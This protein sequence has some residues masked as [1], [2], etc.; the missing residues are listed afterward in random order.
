MGLELVT[1]NSKWVKW[2]PFVVMMW[3]TLQAFQSQAPDFRVFYQ[4]AN[5]VGLGHSAEI[6]SSPAIHD[7]FLYAPGFA[8]L[9]IPFSW[10]NYS[11]AL[12]L[13]CLI[14][15]AVLGVAVREYGAVGF[16][17][18]LWIVR[19]LGI[20]FRY[21]QV[22]SLIL[23]V[24]VWALVSHFNRKSTAR[25]SFL[26]FF[27][28]G[29]CAMTKI[30][31][32]SLLVVPWL[33]VQLQSGIGIK[34]VRWE[35][36][37]GLTGVAFVLLLPFAFVGVESAIT[38]HQNWFLALID[39]GLPL[40]SHNQSFTAF[41]HRYFSGVPTHVISEGPVP[42]QMGRAW[43][44]SSALASLSIA[45]SL[46]ALGGLLAVLLVL[47]DLSP[48]TAVALLLGLMTLPSH[49]VWK[50]YFVF[51]FPAVAQALRL[52]QTPWRKLLMLVVF[53]GLNL[54][55]FD[56]MGRIWGPRL[57]SASIFLWVEVLLLIVWARW[58]VTRG[59]SDERLLRLPE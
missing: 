48:L 15:A 47:H 7:R 3:A 37:G 53:I 13:W 34:K 51:L 20:D 28:L 9:M 5:E 40:D 39:K 24:S 17:A 44:S 4:A 18:L 12:G 56:W 26:K 55:G 8:W 2:I 32:L 57:E 33:P 38:L 11:V 14:K 41:L 43:L 29:M 16:F 6:Y 25:E 59:R 10:M 21:G 35:R 52:A 45:W 31:P 30:F 22:N 54:S 19:P 50:P 27:L 23:G 1:Q 36:W 46:M 58:S 42:L 49:L